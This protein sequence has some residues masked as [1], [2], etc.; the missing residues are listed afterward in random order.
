MSEEKTPKAPQHLK[1]EQDPPAQ[2]LEGTREELEEEKQESK[3]NATLQVLNNDCEKLHNQNQLTNNDSENTNWKDFSTMPEKCLQKMGYHQG[4]GLGKELQGIAHP[5]DIEKK[6]VFKGAKN[7]RSSSLKYSQFQYGGFLLDQEKVNQPVP[8]TRSTDND[9]TCIE[10]STI[11][12]LMEGMQRLE[13]SNAQ[14]I[15][16]NA[17][18]MSKVEGLVKRI[19]T[20]NS[21]QTQHTLSHAQI[22]AYNANTL[23]EAEGLVEKLEKASTSPQVHFHYPYNAQEKH[24]SGLS[25]HNAPEKHWSDL[26]HLHTSQGVVNPIYTEDIGNEAKGHRTKKRNSKKN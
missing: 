2:K 19:E 6:K 1:K 11:T 12:K 17:L 15:A 22:S 16:N 4:Q 20:L 18:I 7:K 23:S 14:L 5:L 25:P 9:T 24:W 21:I 13:I 10:N 3:G 26:N 8:S